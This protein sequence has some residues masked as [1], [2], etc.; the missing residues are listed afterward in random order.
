MEN[1]VKTKKNHNN[2]NGASLKKAD[3]DA[4]KKKLMEKI[5]SDVVR[6]G[7]RCND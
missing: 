7:V 4:I 3:E 2:A 6:S 1:G 5:K